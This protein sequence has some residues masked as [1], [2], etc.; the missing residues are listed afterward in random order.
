MVRF[1]SPILILLPLTANKCLGLRSL[2][3]KC[4]FYTRPLCTCHIVFLQ[5]QKFSKAAYISP[6]AH[7]L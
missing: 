5:K 2:R 3:L 1:L 7:F 6:L 4:H